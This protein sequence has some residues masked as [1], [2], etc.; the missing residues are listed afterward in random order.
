M[1]RVLYVLERRVVD[2]RLKGGLI[3]D[4]PLL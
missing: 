2:Q 3:V 1:R 4:R